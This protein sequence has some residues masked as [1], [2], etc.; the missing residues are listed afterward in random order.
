[1][2]SFQKNTKGFV[3]SQSKG[4]LLFLVNIFKLLL[5]GGRGP[6][7]EV[8]EAGGGKVESG[9]QSWK[10]EPAQPGVPFDEAPLRLK[11]FLGKYLATLKL[12]TKCHPF[13]FYIYFFNLKSCLSTLENFYTYPQM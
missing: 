13:R 4:L 3:H 12:R 9:K 7:E 11:N 10:G 6:V 1:M 8:R 2:H 5:A